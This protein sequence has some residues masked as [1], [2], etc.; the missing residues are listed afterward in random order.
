MHP[1]VPPY[2]PSHIHQYPAPLSFAPT[3]SVDSS[4]DYVQGAVLSPVVTCE[5]PIYGAHLYVRV[6]GEASLYG[7]QIGWFGGSSSNVSSV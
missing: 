2:G 1:D 3:L 7:T 4:I 5:L 6:P